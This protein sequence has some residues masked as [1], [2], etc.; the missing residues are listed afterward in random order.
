MALTGQ[1]KEVGGTTVVGS[2]WN[3]TLRVLYNPT[4]YVGG[5]EDDPKGPTG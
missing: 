5:L 4:G 3:T 2:L 1:T